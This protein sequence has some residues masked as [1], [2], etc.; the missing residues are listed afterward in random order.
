MAL[1]R[2]VE[3]HFVHF[4][5]LA[6]PR[7]LRRLLDA[8]FEHIWGMLAKWHSG[9]LWELILCISGGWWLNGSGE[10]CGDSFCAFLV[11]GG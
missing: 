4:R 8:H 2:P 9:G 7:A 6:G 10:A 11:L 1:R 5:G 3:A